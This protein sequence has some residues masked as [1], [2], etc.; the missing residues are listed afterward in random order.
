VSIVSTRPAPASLDETLSRREA[1]K[2]DRRRRIIDAAR[3]MIRET[4]NAGLSM[5]ALALRAG[6]SLAT[7]YN[8]FGSKRAVVVAVLQDVRAFEERFSILSASD[9]VDRI[10]RAID[11]HVEFYLADPDF[12][13]TVW[14]A[15]FDTSDDVRTIIFSPR[16]DAFWLR[17][18][19][20]A[21]AVGAIRPEIDLALLLTPLEQVF[22]ASVLAW[23]VGDVRPALLGPTTRLGY[24]LIL[25]GVAGD[26]WRA[27]L[28]NRIVA[29]QHE[30]QAAPAP[31][32]SGSGS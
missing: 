24:A 4:G 9:P 10:F 6:V 5:R 3:E 13:K 27:A 16:R 21:A 15:L 14:S 2:A 22:R 20:Q 18:L 30:L 25:S 17:L 7:P 28:A 19:S 12:Y 29:F 1:G 23:V 32:L 11:L 8:L 26:A 31:T